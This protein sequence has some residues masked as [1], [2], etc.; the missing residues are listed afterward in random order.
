MSVEIRG[1]LHSPS[2][3]ASALQ[4]DPEGLG[5]G[6]SITLAAQMAAQAGDPAEYGRQRGRSDRRGPT[7]NRDVDSP[8]FGRVQR[9]IAGQ[10]GGGP[11][12]QSQVLDP[13]SE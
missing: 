8:P 13:P 3:V 2:E 1:Q 7:V 12:Q 5:A 9:G 11:P 10:L 6:W 4:A